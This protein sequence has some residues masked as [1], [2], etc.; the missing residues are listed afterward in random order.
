MPFKDYRK[1]SPRGMRNGKYHAGIDLVKLKGGVNAPI[2]A[3]TAGKVLY[4]GWGNQG[5]GLG[6][7]GNVVVVEDKN[8]CA[9]IYAHLHEVF[10]KTGQTI[11]KGTVVG[12][13]GNTGDSF[14]AH[15]HYE[16]RK[17]SK[18]NYGWRQDRAAST[19]EPE[20]YLKQFYASKKQSESSR[21][22]YV[23]KAGDTLTKIANKFN[24][25]VKAIAD[26]N[27]IED[28]NIIITGQKLKIPTTSVL[29][30]AFKV[31]QK[32]KIKSSASKYATGE[33]IP[34][35]VKGKTY[36][37]QQIKNNRVLLKEIVSWVYK[38]DVQ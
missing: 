9:H 10:V 32:V 3:F 22:T 23:V 26:L 38:K 5:T 2:E 1:T 6:G 17:S 29:T 7:Y 12:L 31:G 8:G 11:N 36:T 27:K 18:N 37:I 34:G 33:N 14:G 24:T 4:A 21:K 20:D 28:P 19:H 35:W 25:T 13:Q 16:I 15:L 30:P